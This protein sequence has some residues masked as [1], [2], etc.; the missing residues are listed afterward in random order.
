VTVIAASSIST[1]GAITLALQGSSRCGITTARQD[2][3]ATSSRGSR[4]YGA[5]A[6][7][8]VRRI[9]FLNFDWLQSPALG[10]LAHAPAAVPTSVGMPFVCSPLLG[11]QATILQLRSCQAR[12]LSLPVEWPVRR[13]SFRSIMPGCDLRTSWAA[14]FAKIGDEQRIAVGG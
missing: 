14:E 1:P 5:E 3:R 6:N 4:P 8:L 2:S 12:A 13:I 7:V 9:P 11:G 10:S